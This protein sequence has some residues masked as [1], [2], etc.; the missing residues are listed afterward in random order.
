MPTTKK[1]NVYFGLMM[2]C[3]MV[4]GMMSY[5]LVTNGLIGTISWKGILVQ[6]VLC[7]LIAFIAESFIVG[8]VAKKIAFSLPFDKSKQVLVI[9]SLSFFM[10][11]GMVVIMSMYGLATSYLLNPPVGK[12][13]LESY[14][15]LIVKN[16]SFALPL[17]LLIVGP[18]ARYLFKRFVKSG[19]IAISVS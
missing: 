17:Q 12:S 13:P 19:E 3:G 15:S 16:F 1:E 7:F 8:P 6:F 14:M 9:L 18:I 5:N 2:C 4:V 10:V 11:I